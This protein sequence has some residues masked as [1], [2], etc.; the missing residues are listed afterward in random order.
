MLSIGV[1][2][3]MPTWS[4]EQYLRFAGER[5]RPCRD[6]ASQIPIQHPK[7][8]ADLGCGP[9]NSTAVLRERYPDAQTTGV[10]NSREM[11]REASQLVCDWQVATIEVFW[12]RC[13]QTGNRNG[14][15]QEIGTTSSDKVR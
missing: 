1:A 10:D 8:I 4:P 11:I 13:D 15:R 12:S 2:Y 5:T 14:R 9:G 7:I 6:L 3:G